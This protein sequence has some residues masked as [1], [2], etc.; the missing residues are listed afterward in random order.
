MKNSL[1]FQVF[2]RDNYRC[3]LCGRAAQDTSD[4]VLEV[5]HKIPRSKG[6]LDELDNLWTL[7][8]DCN[9]GKSD[10]DLE[11]DLLPRAEILRQKRVAK[12]AKE[13]AEGKREP[14]P[15]IFRR[16]RE[17]KGYTRTEVAEKTKLHLSTIVAL[18]TG[19]PIR[20]D[21]SV[22][23]T[24]LGD[25]LEGDWQLLQQGWLEHETPLI[26]ARDAKREKERHARRMGQYVKRLSRT[27]NKSRKR[28]TRRIR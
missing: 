5:D 24:L 10:S 28:K 2:K 27:S 21:K 15:N 26:A 18:E 8:Y 13:I 3:Q 9:R 25:V 11:S 19:K 23:M 4:L 6:G 17:A 7:C 14:H 1:R 12:I 20:D 22:N 16:L